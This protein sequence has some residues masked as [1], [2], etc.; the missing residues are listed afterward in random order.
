MGDDRIIVHAKGESASAKIWGAYVPVPFALSCLAALF[1]AIFSC[2]AGARTAMDMAQNTGWAGLGMVQ[3]Q[4][5]A[6]CRSK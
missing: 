1:S 2:K 6:R 5:Q 3:V 4:V